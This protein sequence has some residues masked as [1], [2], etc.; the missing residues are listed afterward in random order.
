MTFGTKKRFS[1]PLFI[2]LASILAIAVIAVLVAGIYLNNNPLVNVVSASLQTTEDSFRIKSIKTMAEN[3]FSEETEI[4]Y[5]FSK[6]FGKNG[7]AEITDKE[8]IYRTKEYIYTIDLLD[9]S[10]SFS[11]REEKPLLETLFEAFGLLVDNNT[12][13][14][15][16]LLNKEVFSK[17][18]LDEEEFGRALRKIVFDLADEDYL[19]ENLGFSK[20][21]SG[22]NKT[23]CFKNDLK[24]LARLA[25][26]IVSEAE[27][28]FADKDCHKQLLEL[29]VITSEVEIE[30]NFELTVVLE[31]GYLKSINQKI[32]S[33]DSVIIYDFTFSD[34]GKAKTDEEIVKEF[35]RLKNSQPE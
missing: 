33:N 2:T 8:Y 13:E 17:D 6:D 23:Y 12:S 31:D 4:E 1:K 15:A 27:F 21:E 26:S 9:G 3:G 16:S 18:V 28:A 29:F 11:K 35:E 22:S 34:F 20:T 32:F 7:F 10:K 24:S 25:H 5:I 30:L 14:I 19:I